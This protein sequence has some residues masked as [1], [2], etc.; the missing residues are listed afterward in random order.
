MVTVP[1]RPGRA[2][3]I[4]GF[5][6]SPPRLRSTV[7]RNCAICRLSSSARSCPH[8]GSS[9]SNLFAVASVSKRPPVAFAVGSAT[10]MM[11][12]APGVFRAI[13]YI[14]L[15]F[16]VSAEQGAQTSVHLATSPELGGVSGRYFT[17]SKATPA[18][19][20]FDTPENRAL[21]WALSEAAVA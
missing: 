16:S 1:C 13:S 3:S 17:K 4:V 18:K 7:T 14:S 12:K 6:N 20:R 2:I 5:C 21:L 8:S 15:P 10:P 9:V 11:L 19:N